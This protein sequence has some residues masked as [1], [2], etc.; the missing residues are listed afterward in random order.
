[1]NK[2]ADNGDEVKEIEDKIGHADGVS[3]LFMG[4]LFLI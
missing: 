1:M 2:I 4:D 3:E